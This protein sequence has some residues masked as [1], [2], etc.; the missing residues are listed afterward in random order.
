LLLFEQL[1]RS[2]QALRCV[3]LTALASQGRQMQRPKDS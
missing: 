2:V 3:R 1:N